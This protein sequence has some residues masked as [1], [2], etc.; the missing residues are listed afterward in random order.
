MDRMEYR[1]LVNG[2]DNDY[3]DCL[4]KETEEAQREYLKGC[5]IATNSIADKCLDDIDI[6]IDL[7]TLIKWFDAMGDNITPLMKGK[8]DAIGMC[9][10]LL[11]GGG[12]VD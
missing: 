8:K 1:K 11:I 5:L 3:C 2:L 7:E 4:N 12:F 6:K 9:L 10:F